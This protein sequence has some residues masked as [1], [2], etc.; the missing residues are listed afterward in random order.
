MTGR[1]PV[2]EYLRTPYSPDAE[3][4]AGRVVTRNVGTQ[5]HGFIQ[6]AIAAYLRQFRKEYGI[7]VFT[8]TRLRMSG[9]GDHRI[10]DVLVVKTPY[11][12]GRVIVDVPLVTVEV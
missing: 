4:I 3:L 5:K 12:R 7:E 10:P 1:V 9:A 2:D 6:A 11:T 8:E